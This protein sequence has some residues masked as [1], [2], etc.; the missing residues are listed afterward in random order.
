MGNGAR[1]GRSATDGNAVE[2]VCGN[3]SSPFRP[4]QLSRCVDLCIRMRMLTRIHASLHADPYTRTSPRDDFLLLLPNP[5][6]V[7]SAQRRKAASKKNSEKPVHWIY[8]SGRNDHRAVTSRGRS[9]E[10]LSASSKP[11][12]RTCDLWSE[13]PLQLCSSLPIHAAC[14]STRPHSVDPYACTCESA[15]S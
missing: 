6:L 3:H 1:R 12:W 7:R 13:L 9:A 10:A 14:Y 15:L 5:P 2:D 11:Q 8:S 4:Y